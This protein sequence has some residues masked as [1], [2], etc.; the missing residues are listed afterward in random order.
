MTMTLWQIDLVPWYVFLIYF[1]ISAL[2][3]KPTKVSETPAKRILHL[4]PML[5]AGFL[6]FSPSLRIGPLGA[7]FVPGIPAVQY[8][9]IGLTFLGA[10]IAIWARYRLGQYWSSR[11]TL[12][13]DHQLIRS[14]PYAYVRHPLY[15]GLLVGIAGTALVLGEWR[16]VG[17]FMLAL[18]SFWRKAA[19][20][21]SLL[22]SEFGEYTEYRRHT[23]F[24]MPRFR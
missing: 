24:L 8:C 6:L 2:R 9:G 23:G 10:A 1:G 5:L 19:N 17:A 4:G 18:A 22:S 14:G 16:G 12:K 15:T 21:E 13:V 3:V 11:V 7:R 20:E